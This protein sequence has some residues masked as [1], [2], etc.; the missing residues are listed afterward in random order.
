[1]LVLARSDARYPFA[2]AMKRRIIYHRGP[3]NSGKTY[4]ALRRLCGASSG[5][6]CGPLRLLAMEVYDTVNMEGVYCNLVTGQERKEVPFAQH[7]SCTI[8]MANVTKPIEVAVIDEIQMINDEYRG[9]AWTRALLGLQAEEVHV[10]GDPSALPLLE[11]LC[12]ATGDDLVHHEYERF[13]PLSV[14][15]SSLKG[16]FANVEPGDCIVAFSRREIF[17]VKRQVELA[18]SQK[19]C[20]VYGGLPPETRQQQAKLFNEPGS[21]YEVLVAS[22]AVGMGLNLNIKRVVFYSLHKFNGVEKQVI[23]A[24]MVKQIAGRAGRR[25]SIYPEGVSTTFF[26]ADV[27]LLVDA[28]QQPVVSIS[29]A[30]LFPFFEQVELFASQVPDVSF[31]KLLDRFAETTRTDG[32]YFLCRTDNFR[33]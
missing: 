33:A 28:L 7:T 16:N 13:V 17:E 24:P 26:S 19:C 18:T 14:D 8:E 32:S 1:M 23:A 6:Y 3:T 15:K 25:G 27:P 22:D 2:R 21:G 30:G 31:S 4:N 29:A 20:V 10:C 11:G 9:W 12:A 5:V